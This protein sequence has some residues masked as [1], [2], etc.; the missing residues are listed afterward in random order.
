MSHQPSQPSQS[1]QPEYAPITPK[2]HPLED[3]FSKDKHPRH[4]LGQ[5]VPK[6]S[7]LLKQNRK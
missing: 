5:G 2:N 6:D 1:S 4:P 3:Y 7:E